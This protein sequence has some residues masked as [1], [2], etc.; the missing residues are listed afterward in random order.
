MRPFRADVVAKKLLI[1]SLSDPKILKDQGT[2]QKA[3]RDRG[4]GQEVPG[5][6]GHGVQGG[7]GQVVRVPHGDQGQGQEVLTDTKAQEDLQGPTRIAT[8]MFV[9]GYWNCT[10]TGE[11][12]HRH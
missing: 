11:G 8:T 1:R 6:P 9:T 3:P 4:T 5:D 2:G 12:P 10:V 7:L